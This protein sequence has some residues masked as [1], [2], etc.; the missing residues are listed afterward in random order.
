MPKSSSNVRKTISFIIRVWVPCIRIASP[1]IAFDILWWCF[2]CFGHISFLPYAFTN[3]CVYLYTVCVCTANINSNE[4]RTVN[5]QIFLAIASRLSHFVNNWA[6][7][8]GFVKMFH[9]RYTIICYSN[10]YLTHSLCVHDPKQSIFH[11]LGHPTFF[12]HPPQLVCFHFEIY[13][14]MMFCTVHV[15]QCYLLCSL[16][17]LCFNLIFTV[18]I[19]RLVSRAVGLYNVMHPIWIGYTTMTKLIDSVWCS[20]GYA[21]R[22]TPDV[23]AN[24]L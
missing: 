6:Q 16:M 17:T 3:I 9:E 18:L 19:I 12:A 4:N 8:A 2:F 22:V 13:Y 15:A 11:E 21:I 20:I 14:F 10:V 7:H 5:G 23:L 24:Y 1:L